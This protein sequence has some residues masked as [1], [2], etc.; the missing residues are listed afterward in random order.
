MLTSL[1]TRGLNLLKPTAQFA[2]RSAF[3]TT[4]KAMNDDDEEHVLEEDNRPLYELRTYQL[5]PE[6][7]MDYLALTG[8][9]AF[10]ARTDASKLNFFGMGE[11]GDV[12]NSVVHLWEYDDLDHRTEV[13]A[14][15]AT[16]AGFGEYI[17]TIRP[18]LMSQ[19]SFLTRGEID[20]EVAEN[21]A[22]GS[23]KYML[24]AFQ[25]EDFLAE[26]EFFDDDNQVDVVGT[27]NTVVG[28]NTISYRL[29]RA[30]SFQP[31]L[32][33][34]EDSQVYHKSQLLIPTPFSPAQ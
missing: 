16:D 17:A 34:G 3:H 26:E 14:S 27:F 7:F 21:Q 22:P 11:M 4:S 20:A 19:E 13:R 5:K 10:K 25:G 9:D 31:L 2:A 33:A 15:L 30:E 12:C 8:S 28:D 18:W 23:G 32:E 1:R 6:H 29:L 24:Q